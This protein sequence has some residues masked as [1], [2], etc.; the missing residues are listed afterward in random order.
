MVYKCFDK[1]AHGGAIKNE[2]I[3]NTELAAELRER[4]IRK[5]K[6]RKVHSSVIDSN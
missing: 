5:F 3:P 2:N 4:I 6:K 1:K